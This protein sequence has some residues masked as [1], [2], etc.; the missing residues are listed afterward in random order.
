MKR[1]D[2]NI[3]LILSCTKMKDAEEPKR[4]PYDL[5]PVRLFTA[6]EGEE[7]HS[8]AIR[9]DMKAMGIDVSKN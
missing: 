3:A 9:N 1:E 4:W 7:I 5:Q 8:F 6:E 2:K